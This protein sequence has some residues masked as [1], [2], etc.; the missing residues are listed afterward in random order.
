MLSPGLV[1]SLWVLLFHNCCQDYLLGN[2]S[3]NQGDSASVYPPRACRAP[4][5]SHGCWSGEGEGEVAVGRWAGQGEFPVP[6][7]HGPLPGA[8]GSGRDHVA[9]S[10]CPPHLAGALAP[11]AVW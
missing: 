4:G 6:Q 3:L 8:N 11:L 5:K 7:T 10:W 2:N 1:L 9:I